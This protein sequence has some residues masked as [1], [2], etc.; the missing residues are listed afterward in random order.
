MYICTYVYIYTYIYVYVCKYIHSPGPHPGQSQG[1]QG[2]R[3]QRKRAAVAEWPD[4][5]SGKSVP[6]CTYCRKL[7]CRQLLRI[8]MYIYIFIYIYHALLC[9]HTHTHIHTHTHTQIRTMLSSALCASPT[10]S[11]GL[12]STR[13]HMAC[14]FFGLGI[15]F[16]F[17]LGFDF[18]R[19]GRNIKD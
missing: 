7:L 1:E 4:K 15:L 5:N 10:S 16:F 6:Q 19:L 3:R 17:C 2:T 9:T 14:V 8:Y 13:A 11:L 12:R 18:P